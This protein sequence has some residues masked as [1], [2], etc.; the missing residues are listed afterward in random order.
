MK[1]EQAAIS[2]AV[3]GLYN[4]VLHRDADPGGLMTYVRLIRDGVISVTE[5]EEI[6]LDSD[7]YKS[8]HAKGV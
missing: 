2:K 5:L 3:N 7:E 6:L 4:K 1:L 8:S